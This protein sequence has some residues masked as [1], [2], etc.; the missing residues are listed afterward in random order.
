MV[1][2]GVIHRQDK[3]E[4]FEVGWG[5]LSRAQMLQIVSTL[6]CMLDCAGIGWSA[7]VGF[8][9]RCWHRLRRA[10]PAESDVGAQAPQER[11][12]LEDRRDERL[13]QDG[14]RRV[15]LQESGHL[16]SEGTAGAR[17]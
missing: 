13:L 1:N 12:R 6:G 3:I 2:I 7:D 5:Y 11:A 14:Q 15:G 17:R 9:R 8:L 10:V 4:L 16:L